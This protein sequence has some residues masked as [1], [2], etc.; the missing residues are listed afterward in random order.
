MNRSG[1]RQL[2]HGYSMIEIMV[3]VFVMAM[4]ILGMTGLQT[5]SMKHNSQSLQRTKAAYLSYEILDRMRA[6]AQLDYAV[7]VGAAP[8]KQECFSANCTPEQMR[9]FDIAEWKCALGR[10]AASDV[11]QGMAANVN[12]MQ[13]VVDSLPGGDGSISCIQTAGLKA[14]TVT[15]QWL[16]RGS[17]AS[18]GVPALRTFA[19]TSTI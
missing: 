2:Q 17:G 8:Q 12:A 15:V 9:T 10:H 14:C 4:G 16:E 7:A 19:V 6:N 18:G 3:S 5:A 13:L 11:C 1:T